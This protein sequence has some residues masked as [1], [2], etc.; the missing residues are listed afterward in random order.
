MF[1][2]ELATL[3]ATFNADQAITEL[4]L[5]PQQYA[6]AAA[7]LQHLGL[8]D[9]DGDANHASGIARTRLTATAVLAVGPTLFPQLD[10]EDYVA[11]ILS[12]LERDRE[13]ERMFLTE[14]LLETTGIPLPRME[15]LLRALEALNIV[16][17]HLPGG[18]SGSYSAV[19]L[20]VKGRR[21]LRGDEGLAD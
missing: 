13:P 14:R 19:D 5:T 1:E 21:V 10:W 16:E 17:G 4:L 20:T 15:L 18:A 3:W 2:T 9:I 6:E 7:E 11:R 8:V 12:S